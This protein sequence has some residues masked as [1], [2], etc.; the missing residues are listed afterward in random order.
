MMMVRTCQVFAAVFN[1]SRQDSNSRE[2]INSN[3]NVLSL[4]IFSFNFERS[5]HLR[6]GHR[7]RKHL[8]TLSVQSFLLTYTAKVW[9]C[10]WSVGAIYDYGDVMVVN[11]WFQGRRG[12]YRD[13]F[14]FAATAADCPSGSNDRK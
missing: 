13:D 4:S 7:Y 5:Y 9:S 8:I 6:D 10:K 2:G 12:R 11:T 3:L 14:D 1:G